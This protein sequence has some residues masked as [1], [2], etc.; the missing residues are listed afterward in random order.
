[1]HDYKW[2]A[3]PLNC[4][5]AMADRLSFDDA[6]KA[7]DP[8]YVEKIEENTKVEADDFFS[9]EE[10]ETALDLDVIEG[11][12]EAPKAQTT[13]TAGGRG[14]KLNLTKPLVVETEVDEF[15]DLEEVEEVEEEEPQAPVTKKKK[16]VIE[17]D[18]GFDDFDL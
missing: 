5:K 18:D 8:N 1:M 11:E 4:Y 6:V 3:E 7:F 14:K 16:I 9:D 13:R 10:E 15:D 12:V 17:D 2:V